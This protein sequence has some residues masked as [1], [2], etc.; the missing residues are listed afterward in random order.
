MQ[1]PT[2]LR[3]AQGARLKRA[4]ARLTLV[5]SL[6]LAGDAAA[7]TIFGA[8]RDRITLR[9]DAASG[10]VAYYAVTCTV[11]G[12]P[13]VLVG[14][15]VEEALEVGDAKHTRYADC[16]VRA[17]DAEGNPGPASRPADADVELLPNVD[18]DGNGGVGIGDHLLLRAHA[19]DGPVALGLWLTLHRIFGCAVDT[20]RRIYLCPEA[21]AP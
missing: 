17:Y 5:A 20:E 1:P 7:E 19:R 3:R 2:T 11:D 15:A 18:L 14:T 9:W 21:A 10:P 8:G 13:D 12:E 4:L 16:R 6:A